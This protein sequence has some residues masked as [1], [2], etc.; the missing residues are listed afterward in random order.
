MTLQELSRKWEQL[1]ICE[2]RADREDYLELV[3]F[4]E[5]AGQWIELL[6]ACLGPARKDSGAEPAEDHLSLAKPFG[7]IYEDQVLFF[8][9]FTGHSVLAMLWPWQDDAHTT[10]KVALIKA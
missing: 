8:Q 4:S 9:E 5:D 6:S 7:G 3:F 2:Q 10:L 1:K